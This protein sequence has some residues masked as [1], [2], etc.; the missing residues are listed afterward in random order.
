MRRSVSVMRFLRRNSIV[1]S[2][3]SLIWIILEDETTAWKQIEDGHGSCMARAWPS[4]TRK[5]RLRETDK[6]TTS[7]SASV[8]SS[9]S[10]ES[11]GCQ[12]CAFRSDDS[13]LERSARERRVELEA[14]REGLRL[15]QLLRHQG[16]CHPQQLFVV[17]SR[18]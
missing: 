17:L 7:S 1:L 13:Q 12:C 8:P 9:E 11:R 18:R 4:S 15:G 3:H 10:N 14:E 6:T 16:L 2:R 5:V